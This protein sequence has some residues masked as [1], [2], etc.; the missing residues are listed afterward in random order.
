MATLL[1]HIFQR[2]GLTPRQVLSLTPGERA[3]LFASMR[4]VLEAEAQALSR[5][6]QRQ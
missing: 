5:M 6:Q 3:F 1:H 4:V 2:T